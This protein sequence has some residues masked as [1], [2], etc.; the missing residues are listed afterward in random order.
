MEGY[1]TDCEYL[2][3]ELDK[4]NLTSNHLRPV[5]ISIPYPGWFYRKT[6]DDGRMK[7]FQRGLETKIYM[8]PSFRPIC[9]YKDINPYYTKK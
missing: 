2:L 1:N 5:A 3:N 8:Y 9:N 4:L 7:V 6:R